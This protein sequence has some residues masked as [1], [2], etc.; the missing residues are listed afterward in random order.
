VTYQKRPRPEPTSEEEFLALL[1]LVG[2]FAFVVRWVWRCLLRKAREQHAEHE[3]TDRDED[4]QL[5]ER[6]PDAADA[7]SEPEYRE[8]DEE[9]HHAAGHG[10]I[11]SRIWRRFASYSRS[12][13]R[14]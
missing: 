8:Q 14:P 2:P 5:P 10:Y 9:R 3:D 11:R 6:Q 4:Q 7:G 12:E 1:I 13:M